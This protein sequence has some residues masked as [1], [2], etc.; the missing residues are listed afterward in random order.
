MVLQRIKEGCHLGYQ[1]GTILESLNLQVLD[2]PDTW[3]WERNGSVVKCLTQD[4][5]VAGLSLLHCVPEQDTLL[6]A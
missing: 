5:R 4:R 6:L 2:Q 3:F 1:N